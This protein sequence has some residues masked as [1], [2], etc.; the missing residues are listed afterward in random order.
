MVIHRR[1][2]AKRAEE[3]IFWIL[4]ALP[5][6]AVPPATPVGQRIELEL[7]PELARALHASL[8]GERSYFGSRRR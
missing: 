5:E 6:A 2:G 8:G 3:R 7:G 4:G 1:A